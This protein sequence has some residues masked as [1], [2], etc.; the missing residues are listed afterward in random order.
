MISYEQQSGDGSK[1]FAL[2]HCFNEA[3]EIIQLFHT[4]IESSLHKFNPID[5]EIIYHLDNVQFM[6]NISCPSYFIIRECVLSM[7]SIA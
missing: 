3:N 5:L 6:W 2:T 1:I 4:Y 7:C